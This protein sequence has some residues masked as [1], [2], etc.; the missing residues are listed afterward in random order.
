MGDESKCICSCCALYSPFKW[1]LC[2][3]W[4]MGQHLFVP[5]EARHTTDSMPI[6]FLSV[7]ILSFN[8]QKKIITRKWYTYRHI[9]KEAVKCNGLSHG[10]RKA[11]LECDSVKFTAAKKTLIKRFFHNA[12]KLSQSYVL[13]TFSTQISDSAKK[14]IRI[15]LNETFLLK[16]TRLHL[17]NCHLFISFV[18]NEL[19]NN[20]IFVWVFMFRMFEEYSFIFPLFLWN[21]W[22]KKLI[23][24]MFIQGQKL[25]SFLAFQ[26]D[27]MK[28]HTIFM[29]IVLSFPFAIWN[30]NQ[31]N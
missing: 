2:H 4:N 23:M 19:F 8:Q 6:L 13:S 21:F 30:I 18:W 24:K 7:F 10:I 11:I 22:W 28:K 12:L 25:Y 27:Y 29:R 26:P 3:Q 20:E 16:K 14:I 15:Y 31:F 17:Y 5:D 1:R 9:E